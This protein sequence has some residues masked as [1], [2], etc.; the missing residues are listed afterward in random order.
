MGKSSIVNISPS[1]DG[2]IE[3]ARKSFRKSIYVAIFLLIGL[4]LS[5][6]FVTSQTAIREVNHP[7]SD[8]EE[9]HYFEVPNLLSSGNEMV[10]DYSCSSKRIDN[11]SSDA[12][13]SWRIESESGTIIEEWSGGVGGDCGTFSRSMPF[14][15]YTVI[16][17]ESDAVLDQKIELHI[18]KS[19]QIEGHLIALI[20]GLVLGGDTLWRKRKKVKSLS[21]PLPIHK[22]AQKKVWQEVNERMEDDWQKT[23]QISKY[24]EMISLPQ[25]DTS[26]EKSY[27]EPLVFQESPSPEAE[28]SPLVEEKKIADIADLG[29]GTMKGLEGP[30]NKD[31]SI[32]QVKDIWDL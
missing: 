12:Q 20:I 7:E 21:S 29:Q 2:G 18:W 25:S 14:G 30:L 5:W 22:Q 26:F 16:S 4:Q 15:K 27:D 32:K 3:D 24:E 31:E 10:V 8:F 17:D 11:T 9:I 1:D 13:V 6:A 28:T 23:A 19:L